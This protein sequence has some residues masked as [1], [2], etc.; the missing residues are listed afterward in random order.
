[1]SDS[2]NNVI[3]SASSTSNHPPLKAGNRIRSTLAGR[4]GVV[5]RT[6]DDGS[7]SVC[8]DDGEPQAEGLG[9]ERMP[10]SMLELI[11]T[12]PAL[13]CTP[14]STLPPT[15]SPLLS[16]ERDDQT[17]SHSD[18]PE[19]YPAVYS[20]LPGEFKGMPVSLITHAGRVWMIV[21]EIAA[22]LGDSP[23]AVADLEEGIG[24]IFDKNIPKGGYIKARLAS[25]SVVVRLID[26]E[27][28]GFL[29]LALKDDIARELDEWINAEEMTT[30]EPAAP[31]PLA[32]APEEF[33]RTDY[34]DQL[35]AL[36]YELVDAQ[37][38]IAAQATAVWKISGDIQ[39]NAEIGCITN[40]A[41]TAIDLAQQLEALL[42]KHDSL[43]TLLNRR[44]FKEPSAD[45]TMPESVWLGLVAEMSNARAA[46]GNEDMWRLSQY[47]NSLRAYAAHSADAGAAL[48]FLQSF[49]Q[50][51]GAYLYDHEDSGS[52][53]WAWNKGHSPQERRKA[54]MAH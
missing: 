13:R 30:D 9:H 7:A 39:D 1:M 26:R 42:D 52:V 53:A 35:S 37:C 20:L 15:S 51:R 32:S 3:M 17:E 33:Q 10:R 22:V 16:P 6:Y 36:H 38:L 44:L 48:P 45:D 23:E 27:A 47:A 50:Q 5:A 12:T 8:W 11:N 46:W 34:L 21:D 49:M 24:L 40:L 4:T 54:E 28:I 2:T 41:K 29:R 25:T 31:V 14:A 43:L 19:Q 18:A